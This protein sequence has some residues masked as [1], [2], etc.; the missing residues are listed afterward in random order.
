MV[1]AFVGKKVSRS[2]SISVANCLSTMRNA[3]FLGTEKA[4]SHGRPI[5]V[6]S[7]GGYKRGRIVGSSLLDLGI[8]VLPR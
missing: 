2:P 4:A 3:S 8:P 7:Q 6:W 5:E 1:I